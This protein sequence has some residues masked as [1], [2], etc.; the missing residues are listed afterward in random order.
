M[1]V[2]VKVTAPLAEYHVIVLI[3]LKPHM[4]LE[5]P[6]LEKEEVE[7]LLLAAI[8]PLLLAT[9]MLLLPS[10]EAEE[11]VVAECFTNLNSSRF[12]VRSANSVH[13]PINPAFVVYTS[14]LGS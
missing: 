3:M 6:P 4:S 5:V 12:I 10:R 2:F 8:G 7:S 9:S 1:L 14:I 11:L 13:V